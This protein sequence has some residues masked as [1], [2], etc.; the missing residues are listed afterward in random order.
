[1]QETPVCHTAAE[2]RPAHLWRGAAS[3]SVMAR[4]MDIYFTYQAAELEGL[5]GRLKEAPDPAAREAVRAAAEIDV[6][7]RRRV[8]ARW[9]QWLLHTRTRRNNECG[10]HSVSLAVAHR[11][12][13]VVVRLS[14]LPGTPY[15]LELQHMRAY[16]SSDGLQ[17]WQH[18][19]MLAPQRLT[20]DGAA[21]G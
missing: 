10:L 7:H 16:E 11:G 5:C 13:S 14:M 15:H 2:L 12:H 3:L 1:V 8:S 21:S 9:T 4:E 18:P 20:D 6:S 19:V 17:F